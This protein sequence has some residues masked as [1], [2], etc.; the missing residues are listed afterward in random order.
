MDLLGVNYYQPRRVKA[1][2]QRGP[3]NPCQPFTPPRFFDYYD[4][5]RKMNP[6]RAEIYEQGSHDILV[7]LRDHYGNIPS[8]ISRETAWESREAR[9]QGRVMARSR[10]TTAS[11]SS[12]IIL[13][14][15]HKALE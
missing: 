7:N 3:H 2:Q 15:L 13:I 6:H 10:M 9:L 11:A 12:G 5:G 14:W 4:A 8:Y 1:P